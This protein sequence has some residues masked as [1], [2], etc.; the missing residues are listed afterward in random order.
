[1]KARLF[2]LLLLAT[3]PVFAFVGLANAQTFR[4]GASAH[5]AIGEKIN[6]TAWIAAA[7]VD[8]AGHVD[9]DLFCAGQNVIISGDVTGDVICAAQTITISGK[10]N[11]DVRVAG[12]TVAIGGTIDGSASVIGQTM[13]LDGRATIG[14]DASFAGQ[15]ARVSGV[16]NRDLTIASTT[17]TIGAP[18]G[19]DITAYV[20]NL[21]LTDSANVGG[22][23]DYTSSQ[24]LTQESGARIGGEVDYTEYEVERRPDTGVGL[25]AAIFGTLMIVVSALALSLVIPRELH[26][27]TTTTLQSQR[28][29]M[30]AVIVGLAASIVVP[31]ALAL[32][33]LSVLTIPFA[34]I[35][36]VAWLL[37]LLLSGAFAAYYLGRIIWRDQNNAIVIML[38]GSLVLALLLFIPLLNVFV[39]MLAVWYGVG[40]I[41]LQLKQREIVPQYVMK[42]PQRKH[43][44]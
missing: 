9:G 34:L 31:I 37:V 17:A 24:E 7:T 4:S 18:V 13:T 27:T 26:Q 1:M 40:A 10:V 2:G 19:R 39:L 16:V 14:R 36:G 12:Q 25:T 35:G 33:M 43:K 22:N 20:E 23:I 15:T 38:I 5:V 6:E 41:V 11:G 3:L 32:L 8:I 30:L 42:S 28:N 29:L 21:T 44:K